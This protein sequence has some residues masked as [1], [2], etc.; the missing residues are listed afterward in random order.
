MPKTPEEL[1]EELAKWFCMRQPV[2]DEHPLQMAERL[3]AAAAEVEALRAL[4]DDDPA[5]KDGEG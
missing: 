1:L 4:A 2:R 3:R 5:R